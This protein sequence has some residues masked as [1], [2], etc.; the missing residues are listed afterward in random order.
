[1]RRAPILICEILI[2]EILA[3]ETVV[4]GI[5]ACE[6]LARKLLVCRSFARDSRCDQLQK[7]VAKQ[8]QIFPAAEVM[9]YLYPR[10]MPDPIQPAHRI[11]ILAVSQPLKQQDL[12]R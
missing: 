6:I 1:M 4:C 7:P 5:P 12:C 11:A 8:S 2:C 10:G 9:K 3:C